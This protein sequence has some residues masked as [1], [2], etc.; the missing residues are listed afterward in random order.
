MTYMGER[1]ADT[2]H[3]EIREQNKPGDIAGAIER[4]KCS[5]IPVDSGSLIVLDPRH[6]PAKLLEKLTTPNSYGVTIA[7][8]F[9]T[10]DGDGVYVV[11]SFQDDAGTWEHLIAPM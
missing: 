8:A 4:T 7:V 11:E 1:V 10:V 3:P 9:S 2:S 6:L 5:A